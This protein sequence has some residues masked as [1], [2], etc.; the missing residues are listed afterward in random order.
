[1]RLATPRKHVVE[2]VMIITHVTQSSSLSVEES[3]VK[4]VVESKPTSGGVLVGSMGIMFMDITQQI[5]PT[6][7]V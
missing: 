4:C 2:Q 6:S 1:M 5:M 7:V 3:T